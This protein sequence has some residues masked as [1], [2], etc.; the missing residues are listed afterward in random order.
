MQRDTVRLADVALAVGYENYATFRRVFL[1]R[2]GKTPRT[3]KA[4]DGRK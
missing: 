2:T 3:W 4:T 1:R